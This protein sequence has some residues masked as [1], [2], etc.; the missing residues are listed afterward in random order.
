MV[1]R[2]D[3]EER[4]NSGLLSAMELCRKR[5]NEINAQA[6][7]HYRNETEKINYMISHYKK[8]NAKLSNNISKYANSMVLKPDNAFE[9]NRKITECRRLIAKN[10]SLIEHLRQ[11]ASEVTTGFVIPAQKIAAKLNNIYNKLCDRIDYN[12]T[13]LVDYMWSVYNVVV[14]GKDGLWTLY[15]PYYMRSIPGYDDTID[16]TLRELFPWYHGKEN[17]D[18]L[19]YELKDW[20][21]GVNLSNTR[22]S[23]VDPDPFMAGANDSCFCRMIEELI[24]SGRYFTGETL[25]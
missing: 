2:D 7:E 18:Y 12:C 15:D 1:T 13:Y 17:A 8:E 22:Y 20:N 23:K 16:A 24:N 11:E 21:Y 14:L 19:Y 25:G 9:L 5:T 4:L 3:I 10:K 6:L